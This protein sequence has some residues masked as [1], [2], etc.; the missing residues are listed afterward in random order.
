M[1]SDALTKHTEAGAT[2]TFKSIAALSKP[3]EQRTQLN[4][5]ILLRQQNLHLS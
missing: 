4:R 3:A 2:A 5:K 1:N